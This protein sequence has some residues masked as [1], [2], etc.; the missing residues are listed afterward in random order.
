MTLVVLN[1]LIYGMT[2]GQVSG[3][4]TNEF[5]DD[6]HIDDKTPPFDVVKLAHDAGAVFSCRVTSHRNFESTLTE[7]FE[8]EGFSLVEISSLCQPYGAGK[9]AELE[10]WTEEEEVL[11]NKR[12]PLP[13]PFKE[14]TSLITDKDILTAEFTSNIKNRYGIVM[15]GSAGG[16]VQA[17]GKLLANAGILAGLES[18]MKGED[19]ITIGT[20][21]S[22]AE[23]ILS[24]KPINYTGL[25][26]PDLAIILTQDG[27]IKIKDKLDKDSEILADD[28]L[29]L[30]GFNNVTY[31]N[32]TKIG[33]KKGAV[34]S[35][36]TY[37]MIKSGLMPIAAFEKAVSSHKY[38]D[39]LMATIKK[40]E[41]EL[42]DCH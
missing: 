3:L 15:A 29:E 17:A 24:R 36:I 30:E 14:T 11:R 7:A 31:I 18:T 37:W 4:S 32:F 41:E 2:G 8:V 1:N 35:A 28:S 39:I 42:F 27:L 20:G 25:E 5:K 9:M 33:R 10:A 23:V 34:L 16:G 22:V 12:A 26:K 19:P 40:T 6:R 21:F 13:P 38:A